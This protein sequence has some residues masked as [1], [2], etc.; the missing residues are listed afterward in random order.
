MIQPNKIQ[1]INNKI[2]S[3]PEISAINRTGVRI[4]NNKFNNILTNY[5]YSLNDTDNNRIKALNKALKFNSKNIILKY[6]NLF[7]KMLKSKNKLSQND[8]EKLK[9]DYK[10]I[11]KNN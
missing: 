11:Q 2:V 1:R 10:W 6:I 9:N 5:G 7:K 3:Q 4:L 8:K